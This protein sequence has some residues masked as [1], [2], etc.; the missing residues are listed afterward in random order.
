[1][2]AN[3]L[4]NPRSILIIGGSNDIHKPGGKVLKNLI[5]GKFSGKLFVSNPKEKQVQGIAS[6]K[7]LN[8]L[9]QVDL[10]IIAIAAK[11]TLPAI[12]LLTEKKE[13]KAFIILSAGYSEESEAGAELEKQIVNQINKYNGALI[14]PNCTGILTPNHHSIFT[15]PIPKLDP[16]G[17]DFISGSGATAAFI[18]EAGIAKG[19]SFSSIF[20]VGNSAQLGVEDLLEHLDTTF[21]AEHSSKV[22]LL[23]IETINK[24]Q[25]LLKHAQSLIQKGCKIAAI[26]AGSSEAVGA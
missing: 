3:Q 6:F 4:F 1:M 15:E 8:D 16:K 17:C 7:D 10:A 12:Q 20:S 22:K 21:D 24:P 13:T 9:P 23:Y 18:M 19:L 2:I 5:D 11:Y 26:K 25:K 14:G